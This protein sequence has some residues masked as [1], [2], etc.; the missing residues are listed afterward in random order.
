MTYLRTHEGWMYLAIVMDLYLRKIIGWAM[1]KRMTTPLVARAMQMIVAFLMF[2]GVVPLVARAMQMAIHLRRPAKGLIFH[3]DRGSQYTSQ[4]FQQLLQRH[5][6]RASMS[7]VG[8]CWDNAVVER[9]FGSLKNEWLLKV[10]HLTRQSMKQ[11]VEHYIRYYNQ[12]R[13]HSANGDLSP[14]EFELSQ[15]KV[16]GFA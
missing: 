8:A 3:S 10:Y 9:F 13:R 6:I 14:V 2:A 16:S 1:D 15:M 4:P 11:D 5:A 12:Q 7:G